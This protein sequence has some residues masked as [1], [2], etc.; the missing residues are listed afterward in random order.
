M[1]K[2]FITGIF[3]QDGAYLAELLL[4]KGYHVVGGSRRSSLDY[5]YRLRALGIENQIE[6]INF[7]LNDEFNVA[8][9]IIEG[10]FDEVYNLAAQSFVGASWDLP[11]QTSRTDAMGP[12]YLL[13]SIKRFSPG[14]KFYQASTS[15]MFGLI[16]EPIQNE[17]TPFI[18]DL[19]TAL[20]NYLHTQ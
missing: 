11:I 2:A 5:T 19:L 12:L 8:S 6:I 17:E 1:K 9:V 20:L 15:E 14:T 3:G 16:Q 13:D 4:G 10:K 7:D 18:L